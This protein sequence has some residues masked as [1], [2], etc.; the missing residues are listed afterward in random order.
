MDD[1]N[2]WEGETLGGIVTLAR[3]SG[4]TKSAIFEVLSAAWYREAPRPGRRAFEETSL[5]FI[6]QNSVQAAVFG[7]FWIHVDGLQLPAAQKRR[8]GHH[9]PEACD[10][11]GDFDDL[12]ALDIFERISGDA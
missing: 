3:W 7:I 1:D 2:S 8:I 11:G 10:A 12:R 6:E 4:M 9:V 5:V